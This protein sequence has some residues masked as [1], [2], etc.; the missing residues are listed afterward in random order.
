MTIC[1]IEDYQSQ[2]NAKTPFCGTHS[3]WE[4]FASSSFF[5]VE[6][7]HYVDSAIFKGEETR[8][9]QPLIINEHMMGT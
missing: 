4:D 2:K 3:M 1:L 8:K 6:L 7:H 5:L 9:V